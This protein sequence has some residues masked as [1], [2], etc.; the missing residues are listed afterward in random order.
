MTDDDAELAKLRALLADIRRYWSSWNS[1]GWCGECER[2]ATEGH[3]DDC[4]LG[5]IDRRLGE[6]TAAQL[7]YD[8]SPALQEL[9]ARAAESPSVPSQHRTRVPLY[10]VTDPVERAERYAD[11]FRSETRRS[12]SW[13][14]RYYELV[15]LLE[16]VLAGGDAWRELAQEVVNDTR[17]VD[18]PL[19][20]TLRQHVEGRELPTGREELGDD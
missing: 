20:E 19:S 2:D 16:D 13:E 15:E 3:Q 7:E 1:D 6:V 9:L 11:A 12:A 4:V 8:E 5:T 10:E 17:G 18:R 14:R